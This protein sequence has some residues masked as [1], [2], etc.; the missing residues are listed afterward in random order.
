M[1]EMEMALRLD[2]IDLA[3]HDFFVDE[4]PHWAFR[5]LREH[6][7]VHWQAQPAPN[8]GFWAV[9]RFHDI[10]EIL[11]DTRT[12]SSAS[13]IT[14]E[15]QD[16]EELEARRSII[17]MDP[18]EHTRLR[19]LVSKLFIRSAVA[20]YE[21]FVRELAQLVLDRALPKGEFDFVQEISRELP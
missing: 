19:R 1:E 14:L 16:P 8:R 12:F 17:D 10:E 11:R 3:N 15:E 4:V 20:G 18:P 5:T 9:T 7:P 6:D 21:G 2:E 13:G